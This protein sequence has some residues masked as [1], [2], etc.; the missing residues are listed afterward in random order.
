MFDELEDVLD[1]SPA[2]FE[3][4][5]EHFEPGWLVAA[6]AKVTGGADVTLRRRKLP[7]DVGLWLPIGMGLFRD[8]SIQETVQHLGLVIGS[9]KG[10]S[11]GAIPRARYR[12][13][14]G[15]VETLFEL[16]AASWSLRGIE[17]GRWRGLSVWAM[18]GSCFS[19]PDTPEND[20]VYGRSSN[21]TT[22]GACPKARVAAL[23]NARTHLMAGFSMGAYAEG[24]LSLLEPLWQKIP[25]SS[26][27][28]VDRGLHSWW[29]FY[30][31]NSTGTERHWLTRARSTTACTVKERLGAHDDLVE[32]ELSPR[33]RKEHPEAPM[34]LLLRRITVSVRTKKGRKRVDL[35]TSAVDPETYPAAEIAA[36]YRERWEI[37]LV[38]DETKTHLLEG[39]T[40]LRSKTAEGVRQE[41]YGAAIAYNLVRLEILRVAQAHKRTPLSI[42]FRHALMLIR[43][44]MVSAWATSPGALPRR[45]ASLEEDLTLLF[46]PRRRGRS[47]PRLIRHK[48]ARYSFYPSRKRPKAKRLPAK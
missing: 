18:D 24:E 21:G 15:P 2:K 44:F 6:F 3:G 39:E 31:L 17:E 9:K 27:T 46:L 4:L 10:I 34:R 37:E 11:A 20:A 5:K 25:D 12:L 19:L 35:L 23:V 22:V 33:M 41:L 47:Y 40:Q 8:R 30:L 1:L 14:S 26:I 45:L 7:V 48:R 38:Y 36:L 13:G 28:L 32:V 29:A 43:N 16:S 42:S